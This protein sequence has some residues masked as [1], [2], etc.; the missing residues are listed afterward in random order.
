MNWQTSTAV[1]MDQLHEIQADCGQLQNDCSA[2]TEGHDSHAE[3]QPPQCSHPP[4]R[5]ATGDHDSGC[6]EDEDEAQRRSR[7]ANG[8]M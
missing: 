4:S 6:A 7:R 1:C 3:G 2:G 8:I 5:R